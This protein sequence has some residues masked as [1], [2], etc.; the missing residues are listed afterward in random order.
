MV[1]ILW[2]LPYIYFSI[3]TKCAQPAILRLWLILYRGTVLLKLPIEK[4]YP[5]GNRTVLFKTYLQYP[6]ALGTEY[7]HRIDIFISYNIE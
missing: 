7:S 2:D 5:V 6:H 4:V 1:L 3:L